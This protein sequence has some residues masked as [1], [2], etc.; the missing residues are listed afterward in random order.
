M[1]M[2]VKNPNSLNTP[3]TKFSNAYALPKAG[4]NQ[5][6]TLLN[7][8]TF[9]DDLRLL[10]ET[11]LDSVVSLRVYPFDIRRNKLGRQYTED[12]PLNVVPSMQGV[13]NV[14]G[15]NIQGVANVDISDSNA[16][17]LTWYLGEVP[18]LYD[19]FLDYAP[20]TNVELYLPYIGFVSLDPVEVMGK[21]LTVRYAVDYMTGNAT[22]YVLRPNA[23]N[24]DELIMTCEGRVAIDIPITARNAAEVARNILMTGVNSAGGVLSGG[25][26]VGMGVARMAAG[27]IIG[28]AMSAAGGLTTLAST[29]VG[30]I[31]SMQI[32]YTKGSIGDGYNGW[33]A[34]QAPH[35]IITRPVISEPDNYA[36]YYGRPSAKTAK[37]NTLTGFT[38]VA[39]VHVEGLGTATQDEIIDVERLLMSGVIL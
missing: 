35:V 1:S 13:I 23:E 9:I 27:D 21:S 26:G 14:G 18:T 31:G 16:N 15:V 22:A 24:I 25:G 10:F 36:H 3:Y 38:K 30:V 29:A 8:Q 39:S 7:N 33:Y 32:H 6:L 12:D 11:P 2:F 20:Y 28:G 19:S 34:P 17:L 5:F 4:V 37:L